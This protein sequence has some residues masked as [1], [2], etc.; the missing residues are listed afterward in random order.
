MRQTW[1]AVLTFALVGGMALSA[2][3]AA[4]DAQAFYRGKHI[5]WI[6]P[7]RP[8]GGYDQYSRLL[9]PYFEAYSGAAVD[10]VNVPG[11]GG[12]KGAVEIFR[13]PAD[14]LHIGVVNG[15]A[16]VASE[17][18]DVRGADYVVAEYNFIGRI[19]AEA[20][21]LIVRADSGI[22]SFEAFLSAGRTIVLGATG[23][24]GSTYVDAVVSGF[25]FGVDQRIVRGFNSSADIRLALLR[26]DIEAM[27]GSVGSS[28]QG[29]EA[30]DYRAIVHT[31]R[32]SIG[33]LKGVPSI[34][35]LTSG[36]DAKA[37]ALIDAW[38]ALA[39]VGRP[40]VAPPGAPADRIEFL[41]AVFG[42]AMNDP[43][44]IEKARA[45]GRELQYAD[46]VEMMQI[47][48]RAT[49]ID[50]MTRDVLTA[51]IRGER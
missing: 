4:E 36:L 34:F 26:G 22:H 7:Y 9:E 8:G 19:A 38:S 6:V 18:A 10:I 12:M 33:L 41:R 42:Q 13:S 46:G 48:T 39:E 31:D 11:A 45:G 16:M 21:A 35:D 15:S 44:F 47:V 2:P 3:A 14:G 30:G 5:K 49:D 37:L 40:V 1:L 24:G 23:S 29:V 27:W 25:V 20:R 43:D 17:I 50:A 51:S 32:R 28:A